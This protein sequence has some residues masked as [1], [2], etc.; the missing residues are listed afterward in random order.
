MKITRRLPVPGKNGVRYE[1]VDIELTPY[2][3]AKAYEE[4]LYE[5]LIE[6]VEIQF[7][8]IAKYE[9]LGVTFEQLAS[10]EKAITCILQNIRFREVDDGYWGFIEKQIKAQI[11]RFT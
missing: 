8:E 5:Y 11:Q 4:K 9:E 3:V 1:D 6:D 7:D 10:N 2:E